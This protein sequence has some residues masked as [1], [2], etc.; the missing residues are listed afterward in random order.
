MSS[1]TTSTN[2]TVNPTLSGALEY[3][4]IGLHRGGR[5][6][7]VEGD[8]NHRQTFSFGSTCEVWKAIDSGL[9]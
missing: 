4:N 3:H 5:V 2:T 8:P 6:V 1:S 9:S 7:T